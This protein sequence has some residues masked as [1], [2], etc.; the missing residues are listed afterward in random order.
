MNFEQEAQ[1]A[2]GEVESV[3]M[4]T[5]YTLTNEAHTGVVRS[6][7]SDLTQTEPGYEAK[8]QIVITTV[9]S[10]FNRPPDEYAR[11]VVQINQ[12]P[13]LGKYVVNKVQADVAHY[14]LFCTVSL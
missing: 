5:D 7:F 14:H 10:Q 8:S 11:Q 4:P 3:G 1:L 13:F 2:F 12:G 6:E 9:V